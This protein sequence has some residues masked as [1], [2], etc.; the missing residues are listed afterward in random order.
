MR[1]F[2]ENLRQIIA[3]VRRS[4]HQRNSVRCPAHDDQRASLSVSLGRDGRIVLHCHAG[5]TFENIAAAA[6]IDIREF[7]SARTNTTTKQTIAATYDY[8]DLN[9]TL[10]FQ[11]VRYNPKAFRQRR[12]D[13]N[14]GWIYNLHGITPTL[15]LL[16]GLRQR[17]ADPSDRR[18]HNL[19]DDV[20]LPEGEKDVE[21]LWHLGLLA[22][23]NPMG[24]GKWRDHYAR[25]LVEIGVTSVI[26]LPDNDQ[27]GRTHAADV[28]R[29]CIAVG[30]RARILEL[31]NL[32]AK[33]D[34]SDYLKTHKL[35]DFIALVNQSQAL[36]FVN[37]TAAVD[38]TSR[39]VV[40]NRPG[41][42]PAAAFS[43]A[44]FAEIVAENVLR[45]CFVWCNGLGWQHWTGKR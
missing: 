8:T 45:N 40:A 11:V 21:L 41:I 33:G 24:A 38:A 9:D 10:M 43:D 14:G 29:S 30:L 13:G 7:F 35:E 25:Q 3:D 15:F 4:G 39:S 18:A 31:P 23:T 1:P 22:T 19:P 32:P 42:T 16:P 17:I 12:P 6:N 28:V 27:P 34:V 5:C 44:W 37:G 2:A 36:A 26:V 20:F